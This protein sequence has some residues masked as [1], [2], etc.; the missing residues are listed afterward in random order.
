MK[1]QIK[2]IPCF[3]KDLK[4]LAKRHRSIKADIMSLAASL[5]ENPDQGIDLGGGLRKIRMA[6]T[7]KGRGKSGGARVITLNLIITADETDI[8]LITIYDKADRT[9]ISTA[10]IEEL[11]QKN[12]LK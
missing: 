5:Q 1:Y 7:S 10:E 4:Q 6:I 12:G 2:P 3:L 9:S 11:L 8:L